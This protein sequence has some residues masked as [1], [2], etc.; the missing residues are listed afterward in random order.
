M[1]LFYIKRIYAQITRRAA[2][3]VTIALAAYMLWPAW[4]V[5]IMGPLTATEEAAPPPA[6]PG[7]AAPP[8]E[9]P[10]PEEHTHHV[11]F[12]ERIAWLEPWTYNLA[13]GELEQFPLLFNNELF[14]A[15]LYAGYWLGSEEERLAEARG[16]YTSGGGKYA[17]DREMQAEAFRNWRQ[18]EEFYAWEQEQGLIPDI[19]FGRESDIKFEGRK[20][21]SAGYS[22]TDYKGETPG[23]T[24]P[25]NDIT[26]EGE[27]QLRI[28]GTV[29]RKTHVYVDYDDTREN[30][31]RNQVSVVYKGDPE[32]LVQE[33]AFGDIIL[34]LP[35]TE[36]VS[37]SS[38]RAV[39]GAKVDL[40]YKWARLMAIASREKGR[41]EKATFTGGTE[42]TSVNL[43]DTQYTARKFYL[44]NTAHFGNG[45]DFFAKRD[46]YR[47]P[48]TNEPY[49]AVFV[50]PAQ[51]QVGVTEYFLDAF[52]F[53]DR[54]G[55]TGTET[56]TGQPYI[57]KLDRCKRLNLGTDYT[58]DADKGLIIFNT[59]IDE[60]DKIAVAYIVAKENATS[61]ADILYRVGYT[62]SNTLDKTGTTFN[63]PL[64]C[65]KTDTLGGQLQ[66]YE[67]RNY[68]NLGAT[69]IQP[70]SLVVKIKDNNQN[71]KDDQN[72]PYLH[73]LGL[74]Q[75]NDGRIDAAYYDTNFGYLVVPD[76]DIDENFAR[77]DNNGDGYYDNLPFDYDRNGVVEDKS[78]TETDA[79]P[80]GTLEHR[81]T[82]YAEYQSLKPSYFLQPN[83]IPGSEV[84][85]LNG[86]RLV[87]NRD[88]WLDYDSGFLELL[89]EG[90][91]D[92][93]A[94]L[95][96]TYEYKPLF[97]LLTKSL[98]GGRLQ[99]G[100]DDDRYIGSTLIG[101]FASKPPAGETPQLGEAP[102]YH[103][104][105][106]VDARY[107]IYPEVMTRI[108][109]AVPGAHTTEGST[110]DARAE[111]ARSFKN[112]NTVDAAWVDDMEGARQLSSVSL[113]NVA[114]RPSSPPADPDVD[115][116]N[117]G[118]NLLR[119]DTIR[120]F[121]M[122][123]IDPKWPR[124][125]IE[126][127]QITNLPANPEGEGGEPPHKWGGI[128]YVI[129]PTG[130]DF[131]ESRFEYVEILLNLNN[132]T[133]TAEDDVTGGILHFDLGTIDE[134]SDSDGKLD[135]EDTPDA[136][137]FYN[138]RLDRGE[139]VGFDFNNGPAGGHI[140]VPN[141]GANNNVLDTED[142]DRDGLL[143]NANDYYAYE[144]DLEE[145]L[146]NRSPYVVRAPYGKNPLEPGW[147]VLRVPLAFDEAA[148]IGNPDP[149]KI[150]TLRLWVEA[151]TA[152]DFP[153]STPPSS[154]WLGGIT[155]AAMKWEP[156]ELK[157]AKGRNE[158]KV[159]TK[160]SRHDADYVPLNPR[161][162]PATG[163]LEREQTLVLQ[164]ILTDWEDIGVEETVTTG[165]LVGRLTYGAANNVYDTEDVNHNGILDY[166]EDVGLGPYHIGAANGR[167][168]EEPPAEG[169]TRLAY[170][171]PQDFSRY[172]RLEFWV[173][174]RTPADG[175]GDESAN[176]LVFVRF[177]ADDENYYEFTAQLG[178]GSWQ[179]LVVDLNYMLALQRK[180]QPFIEND[181]TITHGP[182]RIV[183]D[184][185]LLNIM[186]IRVGVKTKTPREGGSNG[187]LDWRE[188]WVNDIRLAGAENLV[189]TAKMTKL[190]LDFGNFVRV[191][192]GVRDVQS[193]FESIGTTGTA[194]TTT[195]S[196]DADA[197]VEL[198]KFM[199]DTWNVRMPLYGSVTKS[200]T[201]T[202][203][204]YDPHQSIY[205]QGKTVSLT[206]KAGLSFGKYKLPSWDLDYSTSDSVNYKYGRVTE[207]DTYSAGV[208]YDIYPRKRWLPTNV[209]T[210]FYRRFRDE[211]Y[212][213][214]EESVNNRFWITD[215]N[216][217]SVTYEPAEDLEITPSYNYSVT[218][219]R[220]DGT[221]ESFDESYALK[222]DYG[223][224]K[225]IRPTTSY[226]STYRETARESGEEPP[227]PDAGDG[228]LL[229]EEETL[230]ITLSTDYSLSVPVEIGKLTDERAV[231]FN[232]WTITP[233]YELS[234]SS[235][236][237]GMTTRPPWDYRVGRFYKI[238]GV[239]DAD[240]R[241]VSWRI[242]HTVTI[243]NRFNPLE[244]LGARKGTKWENWDFIQAD[245]DGSYT[246]ELSATLAGTTRT[247]STTLPD[248]NLQLYGTKNFPLVAA[249][250]DRSTVVLSYYRKKT[251]TERED[252]EVTQKP[253]VSWRAT[254]SRT[255]R[256][257][258]DYYYTNTNNE[259]L[260]AET[261]KRTGIVR[262]KE[263][264]NPSLTFYYDLAVPKGFKIPLLG[265][266]RW[267]NELN[268]SAGVSYTRVR[269]SAN[270]GEDDTD[271]W[272]YTLSGGYYITT[273]LHADVTGSVKQFTNLTQAG[274]DY[275]TVG[276]SGNFE[277]I[278]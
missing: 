217:N 229:G 7:E 80:P 124:E 103:H 235:S 273:N 211:R 133:S 194:R 241:L 137:G 230:D 97:A 29:M 93:T 275:T 71:E 225:G 176:D 205:N 210:D 136:R 19:E 66:R 11:P 114:W 89:I 143:D 56:P 34:S 16:Y 266:L 267:R 116:T 47:D 50:K 251:Y 163:T 108:A 86:V 167:I 185:S 32:E 88:Y 254:W 182:Y 44:L 207:T 164:Y 10:P 120:D 4:A 244:F 138:N 170:Y 270:A 113:K 38:S 152:D 123:D 245:V 43:A 148:A 278:F 81:F 70:T 112:I 46:I 228:L 253:G 198:A 157:P 191:N 192:G 258:A 202:E 15:D 48:Q 183:G 277:I 122:S 128:S 193:G 263:E 186:E 220:V 147:Y 1:V 135:T 162:D 224:V 55:V 188:I 175:G 13:D 250:L 209:R 6:P 168:D 172:S 63:V 184:P 40:K 248:I 255:F 160:D 231:G 187:F 179:K 126:L 96:V 62:P 105:F 49:V 142:Y 111:F 144:I 115:Q 8:G 236:Y 257:R 180:G 117:R 156:P 232:K 208:D 219:D 149:T 212:G 132:M 159:S 74:D 87:P 272:D 215:D 265:T 223:R 233:T 18:Q 57:T 256:T 90:A 85:T 28:E 106:D 150:K 76:V 274:Q 104:I 130:Q 161:E 42:F 53:N 165:G 65:L 169:S 146:H 60:D 154:I 51:W 238:P 262:L 190:S 214:K 234:R 68:Y 222:V 36:F 246:N 84:V 261:D 221:E 37:Y 31:T 78:P 3:A 121:F 268:L 77:R 216:R 206:R 92:P 99:I 189:G 69:N 127:L 252:I 118:R 269:V 141:Y 218:R 177:G 109:D 59:T 151:K 98:L 200:E 82:I 158:M 52:E 30:E 226:N 145:V 9:T 237:E 100:P 204:K 14:F 35:S 242:R 155:F 153:K 203:E 54:E 24:Q 95:E 101:E 213:E 27:L 25:G 107:R 260:D 58:V 39:F 264:T 72:R 5:Q 2:W 166:G 64:K 110:L 102:T 17:V 83:I 227:T 75:N 22:H 240:D 239:G 20:L 73:V 140:H 67:Q 131:T 45:D 271:T 139:D 178:G 125:M 197:T 12:A 174:N 23:Y 181:E 247:I 61:P 94:V 26:M 195:T 171:S 21:F 119:T 243:N 276:L 196:K 173:Y 129:S 199:P 33:A 201:I 259:E 79:Y 41:T 249:Y 134:D 91:D